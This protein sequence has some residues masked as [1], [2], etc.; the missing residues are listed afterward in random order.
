MTLPLHDQND[1]LTLFR[2]MVVR[3]IEQ[4]VTPNFD[5]W[6]EQHLMPREFWRTMGEAGLLLVDMP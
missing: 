1:E 5:Q 4:E 2:D 3:F 6:E